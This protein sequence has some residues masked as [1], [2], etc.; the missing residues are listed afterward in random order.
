M[1]ANVQPILQQAELCLNVTRMSNTQRI[2]KLAPLNTAFAALDALAKPVPA[3]EAEPSNANGQI[4]AADVMA[5]QWPAHATALQDGWAVKADDVADAGGY[6]PVLLAGMPKQVEI[7][8]PMPVGTDAVA[9][10]DAISVRSQ[11]VEAI[12]Q[13]TAGEGV[14]NP[15]G[16]IDASKPLRNAGERLRA[17]DVAVFTAGAVTTV[18]TRAPRC[19]IV[20][21]REDL[22]LM[23]AVQM[24]ARDCE[25]RGGIANLQ[26]GL[27]LD[28]V[29]RSAECDAIVVVGGSG[30]GRRDISVQT[31]ARH[32][33]LVMHGIGLAPGETTAFGSVDGCPVL[34]VPGRLDGALAS[35]LVLGR[36]LLKR[37][38]GDNAE[39]PFMTR[40]LSRKVASAVGLAEIVLV[41]CEG[42][43]AQPLASGSLP[44]W[45]LA[46]ANG[47]LLVPP[48]SEGYP[49]GTEVA[50]NIWP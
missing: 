25:A 38:A 14:S 4:L 16:E 12:S 50:I 37:L 10:V 22:R 24:I 23:P 46:R 42:D 39:E 40:T 28:D 44:L 20:P 3:R 7:G 13:V 19:L 5:R 8:D 6:A 47:W 21:A 27:E 9:P 18:R 36:R 34:V 35:W 43:N 29:F 48:D 1:G 17:V 11:G 2:S 31:L 41:Y 30:S 26:N 32:G 15:G 45:A 33:T 49:P